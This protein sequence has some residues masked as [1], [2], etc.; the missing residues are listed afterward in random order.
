[1]RMAGKWEGWGWMMMDEKRGWLVDEKRGWLV[2]GR[3]EMFDGREAG[4]AGG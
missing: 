1:M 3:M 4:I 2:D